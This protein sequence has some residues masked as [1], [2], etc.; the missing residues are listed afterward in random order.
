M[1]EWFGARPVGVILVPCD[2]AAV[3]GGF[4]EELVVPEADGAVEEL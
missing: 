1:G 4:A 2:Y 3:F